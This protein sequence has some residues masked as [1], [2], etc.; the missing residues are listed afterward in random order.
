MVEVT[1]DG[2]SPV[3]SGS[4]LTLT[5]TITLD[6]DVVHYKNLMTVT[7]RWYGPIGLLTNGTGITVTPP[8]TSLTE[9]HYTSTVILNTVSFADAGSYSCETTVR[10]TT[11][12]FI[13]DGMNSNEME[14]EL[15]GESIDLFM[16]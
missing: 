14:I 3:F 13:I 2:G 6:T 4:V 16:Q 15:Q 7:N 10:H 9:D 5:C 12:Q 8:V 1:H 11:S